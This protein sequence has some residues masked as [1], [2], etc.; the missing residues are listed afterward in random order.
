MP[1][2][3]VITTTDCLQPCLVRGCSLLAPVLAAALPVGVRLMHTGGGETELTWV[4][5]WVAVFLGVAVPRW[6]GGRAARGQGQMAS[7]QK[8]AGL[9]CNHSKIQVVYDCH[10]QQYVYAQLVAATSC[11]TEHGTC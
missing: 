6:K 1:P 5:V 2:P 3:G 11:L 8:A 9:R 7:V 10:E 4:Q